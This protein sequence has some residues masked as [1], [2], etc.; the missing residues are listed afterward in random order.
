MT[1]AK[2]VMLSWKGQQTGPFTVDEIRSKLAAGDVS[3]LHQVKYDGRWLTLEEFLSVRADQT[4]HNRLELGRQQHAQE[5]AGREEF[6]QAQEI[7]L[8]EQHEQQLAEER[9]KQDRLQRRLDDLERQVDRQRQLTPMPPAQGFTQFAPQVPSHS[10]KRTS[11]LAIAALVMSLLNFVPGLNFV[12][13]LLALI[14]GHVALSNIRNDST[15]EGRGMAI[16]ALV[17]TYVLIGLGLAWGV[18]VA[19]GIARLPKY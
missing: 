14:F 3:L 1:A 11:G 16:A 5:N 6:L 4:Q 13:W 19:V 9:A 15:L 7:E 17:I 2:K 10:P 12:T 8:R 18:F